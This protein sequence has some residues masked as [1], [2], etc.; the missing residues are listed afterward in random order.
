MAL[1]GCATDESVRVGYLRRLRLSRRESE[2]VSNALAGRAALAGRGALG[3]LDLHRYYRAYGPAGVDGAVLALAQAA[4]HGAEPEAQSAAWSA[5][6]T[7]FLRYDELVDPPGLLSGS[8]LMQTLRLAPGPLIGALLM[9]VR[10]AQV[11]GAVRT[12]GE[13][14]A[15]AACVA[16]QNGVT[17]AD[18]AEGD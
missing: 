1:D 13:A 17:Q 9:A 3:E 4:A 15:L 7:W 6:Q 2:H 5:L 12:P 16:A 8:D 11:S 10:E 18:E 14:L